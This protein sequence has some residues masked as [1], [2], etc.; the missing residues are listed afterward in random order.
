MSCLLDNERVL[1]STESLPN[2][3]TSL[4]T[5]EKESFSIDVSMSFSLVSMSVIKTAGPSI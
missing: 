2:A 3:D 4:T 5:P 1:K